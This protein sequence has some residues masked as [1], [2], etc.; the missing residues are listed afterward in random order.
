[1]RFDGRE[2][3]VEGIIINYTKGDQPKIYKVVVTNNDCGEK[4]IE[5]VI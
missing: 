3:N 5:K 2:N 4:Y 1:M